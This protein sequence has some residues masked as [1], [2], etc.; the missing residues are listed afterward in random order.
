M[1]YDIDSSSLLHLHLLP[2]LLL[3][4]FHHLLLPPLLLLLD[5]K[6]PNT[7][8]TTIFSYIYFPNSN[9]IP[10][11]ALPTIINHQRKTPN[12]VHVIISFKRD[13]KNTNTNFSPAQR[14]KTPSLA[15][16]K[17]EDDREVYPD[18][19]LLLL[20]L[21]TDRGDAFLLLILFFSSSPAS[22]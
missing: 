9:R 20:L 22:S 17:E 6:W 2:L 18:S 13:T 11:R 1:L 14:K 12:S 8:C 21:V 19:A 15:F 16:G 4:L 5:N 7:N 3:L 10:S